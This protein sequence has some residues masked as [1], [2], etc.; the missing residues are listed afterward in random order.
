M[1]SAALLRHFPTQWN[2][3]RR[4]QGRTDIPLSSEARSLLRTLRLPKTWIDA[5]IVA[6]PLGR[7]RET[8]EILSSEPVSTDPRFVELSW[9]DWEGRTARDLARD[10]KI[11]FRPTHEWDRDTK[12]PNGESAR[13]A[14]ERIRPALAELAATPEPVLIITHKA[15]MRVVLGQAW[16]GDAPEIKR[17]RL[18]P[19]TLGSTGL[20]S[21]PGAPVRLVP[22]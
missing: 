20:V 3:E 10:P 5:R 19:L 4:L 13:E 2:A 15:L 22:R 6:S 16:R 14:W 7:A 12:A 21:D 1:T 9:G 17:G 18:Y 11:D 8:A